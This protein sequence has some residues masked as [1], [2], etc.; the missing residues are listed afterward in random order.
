MQSTYSCA[1]PPDVG[2]PSTV[3]AIDWSGAKARAGQRKGIW[4][5]QTGPDGID[6]SAGRT[7]E[8]TIELVERLATPCVVG[9][10]FSFGAPAWFSRERGCTTID[11]VWELARSDGERWLGPP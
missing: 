4:V 5:A 11:H 1:M 7:R 3:V 9:F 6:D 10:D 8:E 2:I